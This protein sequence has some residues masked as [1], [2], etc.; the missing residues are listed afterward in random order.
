MH[1]GL[2]E[3]LA[4]ITCLNVNIVQCNL[5]LVNNILISTPCFLACYKAAV[6]CILLQR[7]FLLTDL[8]LFAC[9]LLATF[10]LNLLQRFYLMPLIDMALSTVINLI[11]QV[12]QGFCICRVPSSLKMHLNNTLELLQESICCPKMVKLLRARLSRESAISPKM[13]LKCKLRS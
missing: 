5:V 4:T 6:C 10:Q 13:L 9:A 1:A 12:R 8:L 3:C 11:D 2:I 7:S